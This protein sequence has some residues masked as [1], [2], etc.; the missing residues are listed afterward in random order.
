MAELS[1][2]TTY[3]GKLAL[4]QRLVKAAQ[5]RTD[6][7]LAV[8]ELCEAMGELMTALIEKEQG[9]GG[10]GKATTNQASS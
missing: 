3:E 5:Y 1:R 2:P 6:P 9:A 8:R 10:G 4:A 7:K